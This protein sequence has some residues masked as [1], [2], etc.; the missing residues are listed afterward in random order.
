VAPVP[1]CA[2]LPEPGVAHQCSAAAAVA[3]SC[4]GLQLCADQ[5]QL[6]NPDCVGGWV[7]SGLPLLVQFLV[8]VARHKPLYLF[9]QWRGCSC[10]RAVQRDTVQPGTIAVFQAV[11]VMGT[12]CMPLSCGALP[13]RCVQQALRGAELAVSMLAVML[14][15]FCT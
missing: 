12:P 7:C 13:A 9:K 11:A 6:R 15:G 3:V 2:G 8:S 1:L 14:S 10:T 5:V 4:G